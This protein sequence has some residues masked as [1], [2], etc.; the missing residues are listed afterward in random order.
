MEV[1]QL[2]AFLAISQTKNFTKAADI[3]HLTQPSIT[4]R[5][6]LLEQNLGKSLFYR[7]SKFVEL[8]HSGR[9]LLPYAQRICELIEEGKRNVQIEDKFDEYLVLGS[10]HSLWEY[11]L[12]PLINKYKELYPKTAIKIITAH[13]EELIQKVSDNSIDISVSY[14]KPN[15]NHPDLEV[16]PYSSDKVLLVGSPSICFDLNGSSADEILNSNTYIHMNWGKAF[17]SWCEDNIKPTI[18]EYQVDNISIFIKYLLSGK[19]LGFL[20]ESIAK[21]YLKEKTLI[22]YDVKHENPIPTRTIYVLHHNRKKEIRKMV[23]F[24]LEGCLASKN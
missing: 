3:L 9:S 23:S 12:F 16:I 10:T 8:T 13:S 19:G 4:S 14:N 1:E 6:K 15:T 5:I 7:D 21:K 20:P 22:Q 2:K 24:L 17:N 11:I 18:T